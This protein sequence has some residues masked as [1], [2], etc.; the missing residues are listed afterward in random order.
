MNIGMLVEMAA[1]G[2]PERVILG[3]PQR[4]RTAAQ[5]LACAKRAAQ[6]FRRS[7]ADRIGLLDVNSEAV[8]IALF[9]AAL[10]GLPFAP[11]NYRLTDEQLERIVGRL[12]PALILAGPD[13]VDRIP[14]A[15]T[16]T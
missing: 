15:A 8:P 11:V 16:P 4:G 5:L 2:A 7:G 13:I 6:I 12:A 3:E 14:R 9:G 1:E 10:A